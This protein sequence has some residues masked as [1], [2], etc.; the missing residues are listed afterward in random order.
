MPCVANMDFSV[1]RCASANECR[2]LTRQRAF[3][4]QAA[5]PFDELIH[6]QAERDQAPENGMKLC[7][8]HGSG[9]SL[10]GDVT[11]SEIEVGFPGLDNVHVVA[12]D[13]S[14]RLVTIVKTPPVEAQTAIG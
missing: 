12:A 4:K 10:A 1:F 2:V 6:S 11:Q 8:Q 13:R 7:H 14:R 3:T 9:D 5:C